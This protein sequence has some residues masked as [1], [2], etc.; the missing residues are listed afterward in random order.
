[1]KSLSSNVR[2]AELAT[3]GK[4]ISTY[5][6]DEESLQS[7]DFLSII[8]PEISEL[9]E[10][11]TTAYNQDKI[12]SDFYEADAVRDEAVRA[13]GSLIEA[14][15]TI[16]VEATQTA[17]QALKTVFDK[18]GKK[19]ANSAYA[20]ETTQINSL[21]TD[22]SAE[23][24]ADSI[25]ALNGMS[26]A[27]ETLRSAQAAFDEADNA[28][29]KALSQKSDSATSYRKPLLSAINEKLVPFLSAAALVIPDKY[30]AFATRI[31]NAISI[32]NSTI[33][34]RSSSSSSETTTETTTE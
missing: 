6:N 24:L 2:V 29:S 1:M 31:E 30:S 12:K 16:P 8:M 15:L 18:Y 9:S 25:A 32:A 14:Y 4:Q 21:L 33:A 13:L 7:D 19:I 20:T 28:F 23:S 22:L 5:F 3:F 10:T 17:A 27:I 11:L 34:R 26:D